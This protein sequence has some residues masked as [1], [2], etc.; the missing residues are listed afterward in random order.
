MRPHNDSG[1]IIL[2]KSTSLRSEN[3]DKFWWPIS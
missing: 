1:I 3:S 2:Y